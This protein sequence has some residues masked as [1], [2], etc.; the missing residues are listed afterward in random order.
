MTIELV[1]GPSNEVDGW[2]IIN[3]VAFRY[4]MRY[5]I[6]DGHML[7]QHRPLCGPHGSVL[8]REYKDG[9]WTTRAWALVD[10]DEPWVDGAAPGFEHLER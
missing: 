4:Q 2:K 3:I 9:Q 8:A 7:I 6:I 5:R 10:S 1:P